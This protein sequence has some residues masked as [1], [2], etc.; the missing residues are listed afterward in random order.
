MMRK[1][2]LFWLLV[3]FGLLL[4]VGAGLLVARDGV[5]LLTGGS[6]VIVTP[7]PTPVSA[8]PS[9][10]PLVPLP[11]L[12]PNGL[13]VSSPAASPPLTAI[14]SPLLSKG[15]YVDG[16]DLLALVNK[17]LSL[18]PGYEPL[19]LVEFSGMPSFYPGQRIRRE[20]AAYLRQMFDAAAAE[21]LEIVVLSAYRS[22]QDQARA[23]DYWVRQEG[24]EAA[25]RES[26]R[27]GY[28]QHQL[29]TAVDMTNEG[30]SYSL[31]EEFGAT[32]E[33]RWLEA[34]AHRFGFILSYP[35]DKEAITGYKYEPWHFRYVGLEH[36]AAIYERGL[37]LEEYLALE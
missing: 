6:S 16:D 13:V 12:T 37:A 25:E 33:G 29:G 5:A 3:G 26:A 2:S 9:E 21:G 8:L 35:R 15:P 23:F 34:N 17:Q 22:Y 18:A 14:A 31:V 10:T 36:A 24:L 1:K 30:V 32:A 20:A 11:T 27:P 4:L 19:D 28:S 7:T